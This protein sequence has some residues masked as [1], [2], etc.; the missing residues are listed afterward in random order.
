MHYLI[1]KNIQTKCK[2]LII[3]LFGNKDFT[4]K[5]VSVIIPEA[6]YRTKHSA[7]NDVLE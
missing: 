6:L 5:R 7:G 4:K 3:Q 1:K 2:T